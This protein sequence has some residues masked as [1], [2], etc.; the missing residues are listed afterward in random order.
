MTKVYIIAEAGVNHNGSPD[1]AL[2]MIRLAADAGADAVKFQTFI[3]GEVISSKA[4]KAPYQERL[5]SENESQLEMVR[6]FQLDE[7]HHKELL[8]F[9]RSQGLDF[10]ST[11]FDLPSLELLTCRLH[12]PRI[13]VA[14]GE[15]TNLPLLLRAARSGTDIILSTGISSLGEIENALMVIAFGYCTKDTSPSTKAFRENYLSSE[16]Q[17]ALQEKVTLLHCTSEYP[18]PFEDINLLAMDTLRQT[19]GLPV[20]YSDH[21]QGIAVS[22]AAAARGAS[23]LEKHFTLNKNLPGPDHQAS[24]SPDELKQMVRSVRQIEL[25]LG[26]PRKIPAPSELRNL[27]LVRKSLV[28]KKEIKKG[29][30]FTEDNLGLKR[31]G[32]GIEPARYWDYLGRKAEKTYQTDEEIE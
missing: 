8:A 11:P 32:T 4:P 13:K 2:E 1:L 20:G 3:A 21:S 27:T 15:I 25:A 7:D 17:K 16:G 5:T 10:L 23:V 30:M 9:S 28:A 12:L 6:K 14:S 22:I 29:E 26:S 24:L 31:P 18:A 19:F